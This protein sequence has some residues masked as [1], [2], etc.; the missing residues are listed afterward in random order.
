MSGRWKDCRNWMR[1]YKRANVIIGCMLLILLVAIAGLNLT[2]EKAQETSSKSVKVEQKDSENMS[3][4]PLRLDSNSE[5]TKVVQDYYKNVGGHADFVECYNNIEVYT[6]EGKYKDSYVAFAKYDM[7][8][9]DIYTEV[10]G[11]ETLYVEK[12]KENGKYHVSVDVKEKDVK[13]FIDV[14]ANH[15]D[16]RGLMDG[17]QTRYVAAVDSDALLKEALQDLQSVSQTDETAE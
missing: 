5:V 3:A 11:L 13:A 10:P 12:Q 1:R 8:I 17:V 9:K 4:N 2:K 7:K 16:V 15:E 14:V 6:K